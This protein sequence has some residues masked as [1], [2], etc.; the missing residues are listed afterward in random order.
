MRCLIIS[1]IHGSAAA[2]AEVFALNP[3][4]N[5]DHIVVL[6]DL[7]NHGAR[8]HLPE[9]YEPMQVVELL[10]A[11]AA[12]IMAVRGN[13]DGEVDGML[14]N[15]PCNGPYLYLNALC[16][17]ERKVLVTHGHLFD[18]KSAE[19]A[20]KIGLKPGDIVLSGHTHSAGVTEYASGV[21]NVNPGSISLPRGGKEP[22]YG[23]FDDDGFKVFGL[24]TGTIM[25]ELK[26]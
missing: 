4:E 18:V 14:F 17:K 15:F 3:P 21:I 26:L 22:S 12:K 9:G 16:L 19:G 2:L 11:Q 23:I 13:C 24:K 1:D 6:G 7:L 5:F 10:N 25:A 20:A 8:N